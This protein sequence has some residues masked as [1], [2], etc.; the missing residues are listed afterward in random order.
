MEGKA[1]DFKKPMMVVLEGPECT[2]KS[3]VAARLADEFSCSLSKRVRTPDRFAMLN[4]I[5]QD[6]AVQQERTSGG[7]GES[8]IVF[9]RWQLVSDIIYEKYCYNQR[10]ILE[11]LYPIL[12][13][14]CRAANILII[15]MD[16]DE[17]DML[18]RFRTR[19]DRLRNVPEA[20][21]VWHAYSKF[22]DTST[23]NGMCC[24]GDNLGRYLPFKYLNTTGMSM[25]EVYMSV[26]GI[27]N[28]NGGDL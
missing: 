27:I 22:F 23:V 7:S 16:I 28:A 17:A 20:R 5:M 15:Y 11:P 1:V 26:I 2:G 12:G 19:G 8:L 6:I 21:K 4:T 13:D 9:D 14:A 3:T 24:T 10:S 25:D 18:T